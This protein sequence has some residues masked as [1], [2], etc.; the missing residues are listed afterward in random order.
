MLTI[1]N[2][3]IFERAESSESMIANVRK[4][5]AI[6]ARMKVAHWIARLFPRKVS[7]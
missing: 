7:L 4:K 3:T 1:E 5:Y 2:K 6:V